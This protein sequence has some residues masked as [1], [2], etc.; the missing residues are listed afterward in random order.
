MSARSLKVS[1]VT[2]PIEPFGPLPGGSFDAEV[3]LEQ[4]L[5]GEDVAFGGGLLILHEL[6][7]CAV[8]G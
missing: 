4:A 1:V 2:V 3:E 8:S 7:R 6:I 5:W